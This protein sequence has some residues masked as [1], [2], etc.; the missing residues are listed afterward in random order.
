M[1][2]KVVVNRAM[3][4]IAATV[5][6]AIGIL[7]Q[8]VTTNRTSTGYYYP[9]GITNY[10]TGCPNNGGTYLGP[11]SSLGGCYTWNYYHIGFDMFNS[12]TAMYTPVY[13]MESGKVIYIDPNSSWTYNANISNNTAVFISFSTGSGTSYVAVYGHLLRSS[14]R[15]SVGDIVNAGTKI[16]ELGYWSPPHL[17]LGVWPNRSTLPPSPWGRDSINNYP[18]SYGTTSPLSWITTTN[19]SAKCQNGGSVYYHPGGG[20]PVHPQGTLFTVKNDPNYPAGT[21]YVLY[22]NQTRPISSAS[23]L[24]QLYGVGRGF[25]FRDV[26]QISL[27]EYNSYAHGAVLTSSLPYNGRNQPDGRLIQQWGGSE[28]S[29]VTNNGY[30]RPFASAE[31]F[32]NLGYQFCNVAG[33][34]DYSSYTFIPGTEIT[35]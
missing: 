9:L 7:A 26:I 8:S 32:L 34:S 29:I 27:D 5:L 33:V 19:S 16:G 6:L 2:V 22:N 14:V 3:F 18:T 23:L 21:V 25:D 30:R 17:H 24:Y 10:Y 31:A 28:I 12:G 13:A 1:T 15:V 11:D 20:T 35:Q 4:V